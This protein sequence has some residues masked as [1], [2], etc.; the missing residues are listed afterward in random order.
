MLS[1]VF[2]VAHALFLVVLQV[3]ASAI[4]VH[5]VL[6]SECCTRTPAQSMPGCLHRDGSG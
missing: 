1:G 3:V 4:H 5:E 6:C 2:G